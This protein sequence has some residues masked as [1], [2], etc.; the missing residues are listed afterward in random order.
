MRSSFARQLAV[1]LGMT[2]CCGPGSRSSQPS[3]DVTPLSSP[4][5]S[6]PQRP[7]LSSVGS[8]ETVEFVVDRE[9][10]GKDYQTPVNERWTLGVDLKLR[11]SAYY[12]GMPTD[13]NH[14]D[15]V[16]WNAGESGKA[17][18]DAAQ[19]VISEPQLAADAKEVP[20]G[21]SGPSGG[22]GSYWLHIRSDEGDRTR[23]VGAHG[24]QAYGVLDSAFQVV[25]AEFR[26][27]TGRP[28]APNELPQ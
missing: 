11:F 25:V 19:R 9:P 14:M 22:P 1:L 20:D 27:S 18:L 5:L 16:T 12:G 3:P 10:D 7:L 2:V 28:L 8:V 24:S 17:V 15:S 4:P 23:M 6:S 13:M 21:A 26:K